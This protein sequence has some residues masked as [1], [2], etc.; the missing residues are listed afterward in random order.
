MSRFLGVGHGGASALAP[1]NTLVSFDTAAAIGVDVIEFDVRARGGRLVLAHTLL[2]G[3]RGPCLGLDRALAHLA[4][5]RFAGLGLNADVKPVGCEAMLIEALERHGL[6]ERTLVSSQV[7]AVLDR[8][9]AREPR[10]RLG[11]SV[12]GRVAR[13]S[14]RWGAWRAAVLLGLEQGRWQAVMA[15]HRLIDRGLCDAVAERGGSLYGWTVRT[16][17]DLDRLR[18]LGAGGAVSGDPRLFAEEPPG[19]SSAMVP[20][21]SAFKQ[22]V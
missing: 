10:L 13:A 15:Q 21:G 1:A 11:I 7:P 6:L 18:E 5:P 19:P 9:R 20:V 4:S 2:H 22:S 8:L 16:R 17:A 14:R 3:R 12:G